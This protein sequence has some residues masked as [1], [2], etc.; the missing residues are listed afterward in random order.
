MATND[1]INVKVVAE[2]GSVSAGMQAAASDVQASTARMRASAD[3]VSSRF[4]QAF[5]S[6]RERVAEAMS[7]VR[8]AMAGAVDGIRANAGEAAQATEGLA[9][10]SEQ[11]ANRV[12]QATN[13]MRAQLGESF[14][15]VRA[16]FGRGFNINL[17]GVKEGAEQ[18]KKILTDTAAEARRVFES[19]R[20]PQER[21]ASEQARLNALLSA[22]AIDADTYSRAV[23]RA[24]DEMGQAERAGGGLAGMLGRLRGLFGGVIAA[25]SV[26]SIIQMADEYT[27][28]AARIDNAASSQ[29]E[30]NLIQERTRQAANTTYRALAEAQEGFLAF[31]TPMKALGY[32]TAQV[33]DLTDSLAFSF[34]ANAARA[35]QAQAAQDALAKSMQKGRIDADAWAS[36]IAAADN[37]AGQIAKTMGVTEG[38]VLKLGASG[39]LGMRDLVAGLIAAREENKALADGMDASATDGMMRI[40]NAMA[41]F[42]GELNRMTGATS[43]F[44]QVAAFVANHI[45]AIMAGAAAA[46]LVIASTFIPSLTA[47]A[48]AVRALTM[49]VLANPIGLIAAGVALAVAAIVEFGDE[50]DVFGDGMTNLHDLIGATWDAIVE[51]ISSAVGAVSDLF[52]G[53]SDFLGESVGNWQALF[54]AVMAQIYENVAPVV[55]AIIAVFVT[56]W[57]VISGAWGNAP[58]FF[59]NL[60]NSIANVF[61][62]AIE[63]MANKAVG[64]LNGLI[65]MTNS[66]AEAIGLPGID[67]IGSVSVERRNDGGLGAGV[68]ANFS[69]DYLG[70]AGAAIKAR[71]QQRAADRNALAEA[72]AGAGGGS[73]GGGGG[74]G[75]SGG[76][77]GGRGR[78]GRGRGGGAGRDDRMRDWQQELD[79]M[80]LAYAEQ[81]R[82][83]GTHYEFS[84]QAERDF[85][86]AKLALVDAGSK[87]GLDIR[88]KIE[89]VERQMRQERKQLTEQSIAAEEAA[90]NFLLEQQEMQAEQALAMRQISD[91]QALQ[92]QLVFEDQR[93]QIALKGWEDRH[94]LLE[95]EN[96]PVAI[97]KSNEK[98]LELERQ[99]QLQRQR[100]LNEIQQARAEPG[101]NVADGMEQSLQRGLSSMLAMTQSFGQSIRQVFAGIRDAFANEAARM[102]AQWAMQA[103]RKSVIGRALGLQ[104]TATQ[105]ATS[106]AVVG[107]K[108]AETQGVVAA[109]AAQAASGAA[110]SQASIPYIGPAL[111]MAAAA[112]MMAFV[113]GFGGGGGGSST[114]T[115][116][117]RIPSAA[118]GWDIPAGINPLAQ[119]HEQEMVLPAAQANVIRD[120]AD[121]GG[122][123]G[124]PIVINAS[125]GD[126]VHKR[127]LA[128]LLKTMKK[129]YRFT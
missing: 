107:M 101:M 31:N 76:A 104:E 79:T 7:G 85:W 38:E 24:S 41:Q 103:L 89:A 33:L 53:L 1:T 92:A 123:G 66:V 43:A 48:G 114:S 42:F 129:D 110:A 72:S 46:G 126:W 50:I 122:M 55:N 37:I 44:A 112:A 81:Q 108:A 102:T 106:A 3:E 109:N 93:Y 4:A 86:Q 65:G 39:K 15:R 87:V 77:G 119:L 16:E 64:I 47:A 83:A 97:A 12:T 100:V 63:R 62:S 56:A 30:Y 27:Q 11:T 71:A 95:L 128:K 116:V 22:G 61:L 113:S 54:A 73:G 2:H 18:T 88:K 26:G 125:G 35:D 90:G 60:G 23:Q 6:M 51:V 74:G 111:A 94:A 82:E 5:S 98:K 32:S 19:T 67:A 36:M 9:G 80:K 52:G 57:Q 124:G 40:R 121:G 34:T 117:T 78:G 68:A 96:D 29:A 118:A 99:Y 75:G 20:T 70:E 115:S 21:F 13:Q 45:A 84:M 69:R 120:M 58:T 25:V 8:N 17:D 28:M 127:D 49:A 59:G 105:A 14:A 91:E 10:A